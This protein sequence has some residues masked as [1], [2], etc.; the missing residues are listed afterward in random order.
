MSMWEGDQ[1][2]WMGPQNTGLK[3]EMLL[4]VSH[5]KL[6]VRIVSSDHDDD[7]HVTSTTCL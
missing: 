7:G 4:F 1:G 5:V 6:I 3:H 2:G